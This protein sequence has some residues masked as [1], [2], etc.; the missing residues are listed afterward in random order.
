MKI[1]LKEV[2]NSLEDLLPPEFLGNAINEV[3]CISEGCT[4]KL[5]YLI[6]QAYDGS[7]VMCP[8]CKKAI[9]IKPTEI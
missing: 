4:G 2:N 1:F 7:A 8:R 9:I 6:K 3:P 5:H